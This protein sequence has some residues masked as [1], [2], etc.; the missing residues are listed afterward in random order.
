MSLAVNIV[1]LQLFAWF[2]AVKE[3]NVPQQNAIA[4]LLVSKVSQKQKVPVVHS[5]P[6]KK[7]L[8]RK[9]LAKKSLPEKIK[10]A[11]PPKKAVQV[12]KPAPP[13]KQDEPKAPEPVEVAQPTP[14][15]QNAVEVSEQEEELTS[16][17]QPL[18]KSPTPAAIEAVPLFRLTRMPKRLGY[19]PEA[20]KRFY[21]KE[22]RDFGKVATVEAMILV[23]EHGDVVDVHIVKSA[24]A[25]FDAAAKKALLSKLVTVQPGYVGDTPVASWVP[26][27]ITFSLTD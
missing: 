20:L 2:L 8:V 9:E 4:V 19:D 6:S 21:P 11:T 15:Q 14:P 25:N 10:S 23:D 17:Q 7:P 12:V 24:G 27:P 3:L 18:Q 22:E 13:S 1:L 26:I 5:E 16:E